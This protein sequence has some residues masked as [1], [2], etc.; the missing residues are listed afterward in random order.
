MNDLGK[1]PIEVAEILFKGLANN[2]F[3]ILT[4]RN[5]RFAK[6]VKN[7]IQALLKAF[8]SKD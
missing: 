4:D 8:E 6:Q 2:E 1:D 7:R 3:Y 5:R